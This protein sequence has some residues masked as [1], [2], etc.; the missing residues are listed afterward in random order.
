VPDTPVT[1]HLTNEETRCRVRIGTAGWAI[2]ASEREEFT[3]EGS[4]LERYASVFNCVEINSSFYRS[5]KPETYARWAASVPDSFLFAV[6]IPKAITHLARLSDTTLALQSFLA[7]VGM[8]G[9]KLGPVLV[10]LPPSLA[11]ERD[12]ASCFFAEFRLL[13]SGHIVCEP[14]HPTWFEPEGQSLLEEFAIARVGT[15]PAFIPDAALPLIRQNLA[16]RRLHG[17]PR[18]YY[19]SYSPSVLADLSAEFEAKNC[20]YW[21]ILDNTAAGEATPNALQLQR[22][23]LARQ[24]SS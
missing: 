1:D 24:M 18:T 22:L 7:D 17:S 20:S 16:Y 13:F 11:F 4:V 8:L 3:A 21:C 12:L 15:D 14:R 9:S 10:Q 2:P 5:H 23:W 6:K 19:S